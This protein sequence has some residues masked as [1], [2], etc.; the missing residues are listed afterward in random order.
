MYEILLSLS[1]L[2]CRKCVLIKAG[3]A[4]IIYFSGIS[5]VIYERLNTHC[6]KTIGLNMLNDEKKREKITIKIAWSLE[7]EK[8]QGNLII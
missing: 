4:I 2:E 7:F 5:N 3:T 8:V 1:Y 6:I